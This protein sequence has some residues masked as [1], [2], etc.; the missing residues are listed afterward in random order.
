MHDMI[1]QQWPEDTR[2]RRV[3]EGE[4]E[5]YV[6]TLAPN[7]SKLIKLQFLAEAVEGSYRT[8]WRLCYPRAGDGLEHFG[9]RLQIEYT[10][11]ASKKIQEFLE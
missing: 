1:R 4:R 9:P 8:S 2:L 6:P 7:E 11:S 3:D 5:D 10:V